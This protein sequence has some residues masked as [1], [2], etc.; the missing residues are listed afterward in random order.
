MSLF[1][2]AERHMLTCHVCLQIRS[3]LSRLASSASESQAEGAH[4][5]FNHIAS[6]LASATQDSKAWDGHLHDLAESDLPTAVWWLV[7]TKYMDVA[8]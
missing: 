4:K 7:A 2:L 8:E 6:I 1:V 5:L 3:L